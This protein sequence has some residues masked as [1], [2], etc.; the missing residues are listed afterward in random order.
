MECWFIENPVSKD[1]C[2][3][4]T[5]RMSPH[6]EKEFIIVL[7]APSNRQKF[8]LASFLTITMAHRK[9]SENRLR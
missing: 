3:S 2:K 9:T 8:N 4:I 5:L 7:K 1:L 6:A